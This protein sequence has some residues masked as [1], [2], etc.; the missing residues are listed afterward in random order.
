MRTVDRSRENIGA[1]ALPVVEA[2][3]ITSRERRPLDVAG[4]TIEAFMTRNG[5]SR[6]LMVHGAITL[7]A[8]IVLAVA[9]LVLLMRFA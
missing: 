7:A 1:G 8:G 2:G 4:S 3:E 5:L 6:L 9:S